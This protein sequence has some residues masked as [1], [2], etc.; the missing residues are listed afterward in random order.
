MLTYLATFRL[1]C[2]GSAE[3]P[4]AGERCPAIKVQITDFAIHHAAARASWR[5]PSIAALVGW[6]PGRTE[7]VSVELAA[8]SEPPDRSFTTAALQ[9]IAYSKAAESA[10]RLAYGM[11]GCQVGAQRLI[12][13]AGIVAGVWR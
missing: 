8:D 9:T 11:T 12:D 2:A 1:R 3:M 13:A 4:V 7:L 5:L 6:H 10:Q